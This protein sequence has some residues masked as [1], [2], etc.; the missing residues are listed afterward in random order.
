MKPF[1]TDEQGVKHCSKDPAH[2]WMADVP[3]C[4]YCNM[5]QEARVMEAERAREKEKEERRRED[6]VS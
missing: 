4:P 5:T 3:Y 2:I 6:E 1:Y